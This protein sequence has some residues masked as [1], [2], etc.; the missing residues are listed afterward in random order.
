M[1]RATALARGYAA[2]RVAFSKPLLEHPLHVETL[3]DLELE[4]RAGFHLA[5]RVVELLGREECGTASARD[6]ALLRLLVPTAKLFTGKQAVAVASEALETFGGAGYVED[7][8][9]PRLLRDAQVLP[10]WEGTTNVLAL[11]VLRAVSKTD[12]LQ[13]FV[14]D[15]TERVG[16][17]RPELAIAR[18]RILEACAHLTSYAR[19]A[20]HGDRDGLE[21]GARAFAFA[22]ARTY[23]ASL[24][25][26]HASWSL[27]AGDDPAAL[28]AALRWATKE[29]V[30]LIL[31]DERHRAA[32]ELLV[33]KSRLQEERLKKSDYKKSD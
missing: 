2:T 8:G 7:T 28:A 24:L 22:L 31:A 12:A 3:A 10:I 11:D 30:P 9:L 25:C 19:Q 14:E 23:A 16:H 27:D 13:A 6:G 4:C 33:R 18:E 32:S 26:E 1:R 15:I 17:L 29:L 21:A 5:F 20:Q